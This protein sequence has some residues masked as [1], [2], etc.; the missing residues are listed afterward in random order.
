MVENQPARSARRPLDLSGQEFGSLTAQY[1][2]RIIP[3]QG[4][5][6]SCTCAC[7]GT[8]QALASALIRGRIPYCKACARAHRQLQLKQARSNILRFDG[9]SRKALLQPAADLSESERYYFNQLVA[10]RRKVGVTITPAIE[11]SCRQMAI[12]E[13]RQ[14]ERRAA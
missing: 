9:L 1:I 12:L 13:A 10:R 6:W 11:A 14:I 7:G 5:L 2:I 8:H 3:H 4:A